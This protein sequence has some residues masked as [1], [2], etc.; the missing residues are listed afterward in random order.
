MDL[1]WVGHCGAETG[2]SEAA[3]SGQQSHK[4]PFITISERLVAGRRRSSQDAGIGNGTL[5]Y[6]PESTRLHTRGSSKRAFCGKEK[7]KRKPA[8]VLLHY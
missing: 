2:I 6:W 1:A 5:P 4:G 7:E 3:P 8:L